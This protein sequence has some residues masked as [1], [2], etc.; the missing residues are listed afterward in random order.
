MEAE[1]ASLTLKLSQSK[2]VREREDGL[3]KAA[4]Y[5]VRKYFDMFFF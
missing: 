5:H 3:L 4:L 2:G 1:L